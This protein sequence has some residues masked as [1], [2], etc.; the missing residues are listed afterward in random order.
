MQLRK[1][2]LPSALIL[3]FGIALAVAQNITKSVQMSQDPRGPI[4]L[5]ASNNT[6]FPAH[7]LT[8]GPGTPVLT[9]CGTTPSIVGTDTGGIIT[10][11]TTALGCTVTFNKAY[12]A[13]PYCVVVGQTGSG[14]VSPVSWVASTVNFVLTHST[15]SSLLL[16]YICVGSS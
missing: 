16:N 11:G 7:V 10:E 9:S 1:Y 2:L 3:A 4:S 14:F 8:R 6:Y 5:D 13:T 12:A 15:A